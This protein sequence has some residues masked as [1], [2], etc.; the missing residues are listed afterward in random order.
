MV[1][2]ECPTC[3]H[4]NASSMDEPVQWCERCRSAVTSPE[5]IYGLLEEAIVDEM[6]PD[7]QD[8]WI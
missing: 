5:P 1:Q 6:D 4:E 3:G 8:E 2:V 7:L